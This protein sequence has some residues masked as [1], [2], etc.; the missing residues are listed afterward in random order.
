[1]SN[2]LNEYLGRDEAVRLRALELA[3]EFTAV[4]ETVIDNDDVV[5]TAKTFADFVLGKTPG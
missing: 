4:T 1:M 3:L 5:Q 2:T